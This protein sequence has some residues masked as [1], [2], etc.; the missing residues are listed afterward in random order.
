MKNLVIIMALLC[1]IRLHA[2][3]PSEGKLFYGD[4]IDEGTP[5][6]QVIVVNE[7]TGI[8]HVPKYAKGNVGLLKN[9]DINSMYSVHLCYSDDPPIEVSAVQWVAG[10]KLIK[11]MA[12]PELFIGIGCIG[13][14]D[15][16]S[17]V[18]GVRIIGVKNLNQKKVLHK[19]VFFE[20]V[21]PGNGWLCLT[22]IEPGVYALIPV[23][24]WD[25]ASNLPKGKL[26]TVKK[27]DLSPSKSN[28]DIKRFDWDLLPEIQ[29]GLAVLAGKCRASHAETL[30]RKQ[31]NKNRNTQ[32]EP[33]DKPRRGK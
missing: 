31:M 15:I 19:Y 22:D 3:P 33:R 17:Q 4:W 21:I 7:K 9:I 30:I 8:V 24:K 25:A 28:I 32:P 29:P 11:G 12:L 6:H 2:G 1:C 27:T 18:W 14:Y 16:P 20:E 23:R 26:L 13:V 5:L 10:A